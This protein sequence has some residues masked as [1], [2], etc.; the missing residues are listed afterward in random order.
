MLAAPDSSHWVATLSAGVRPGLG[1]I[2]YST[3]AHS[4]CSEIRCVA[5]RAYLHGW[6]GGCKSRST[7]Q[8]LTEGCGD[9]GK[10]C[11]ACNLEGTRTCKY[12]LLSHA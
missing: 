2:R 7:S 1:S 9:M 3:R 12:K 4:R 11:P 10:A 5:T 6:A 8:D